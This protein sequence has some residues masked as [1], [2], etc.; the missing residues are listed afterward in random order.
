MSTVDGVNTWRAPLIPPTHESESD[1]AAPAATADCA[2]CMARG[3]IALLAARREVARIPA[4]KPIDEA[5]SIMNWM[6]RERVS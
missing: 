1:L 6:E 5:R 3:A 2:A 4:A